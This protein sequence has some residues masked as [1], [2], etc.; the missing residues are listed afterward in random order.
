[1]HLIDLGMY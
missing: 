1:M